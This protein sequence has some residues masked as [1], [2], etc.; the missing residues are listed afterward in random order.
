[1]GCERL[2]C[3]AAGNAL[4]QDAVAS[5]PEVGPDHSGVGAFEPEAGMDR[6]EH[7]VRAAARFPL[8]CARE[9]RDVD[10]PGAGA[11]DLLPQSVLVGRRGREF[12][13]R[14]DVHGIR[15]QGRDRAVDDR[16][17]LGSGHEKERRGEGG[18][19]QERPF[20]GANRARARFRAP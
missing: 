7:A 3:Q 18:R 13:R 8:G 14:V 5:G 2:G 20:H 10:G 17:G 12:R 15:V 16:A 9:D 1:M 4:R 11:V 19:D 6:L